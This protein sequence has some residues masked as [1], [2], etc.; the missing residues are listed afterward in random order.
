MA[1][2][3]AT[4]PTLVDITKRL[5]PNGSIAVIGELLSQNNAVVEDLGWKEGNKIDGHQI[6]QRTQLPTS[7]YRLINQGVAPSKSTTAQITEM[8]AI[9]EA[10]GQI[11]VDLALLNGNS[12][13]WRLSENTPF[14]ESMTQK[15]VEKFFYGNAGLDPEQFSGLAMRYSSLS[16]GNAQNIV[17]AGGTGSDNSSIW[18]IPTN[19]DSFFGIYPKGSQAGLIHEDL[20]IDD[21][22]D[23]SNNRFRA[24]LDRYQWKHAIALVDWRHVGRIA[25]IDIS[26][27]VAQS[28][29]A[30][31]T[32]Q[33]IK[34]AARL[35]SLDG[36]KIYMN[37]TLL[38]YLEIEQR[39][40]VSVGGQLSYAVIDGKPVTSFRGMP[41]RIVDQLLETE[42]RVV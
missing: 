32:T 27:L 21:A 10:R 7:Y 37:R 20:G 6:T 19:S 41:I 38:Q 34:M 25:N 30:I 36:V 14:L 2:I 29:Q 1:T 15:F 8:T 11:D 42:A 18:F 12:A 17:D 13:A 40:A 28:G 39:A 3:G 24:Y 26:N 31:M 16:A 9:L 4:L 22:F 33:M 35:R 5:D 23:S